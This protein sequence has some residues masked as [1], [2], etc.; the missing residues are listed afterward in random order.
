MVATQSQLILLKSQEIARDIIAKAV[1]LHRLGLGVTDSYESDVDIGLSA[2]ESQ[3]L[4]ETSH[5]VQEVIER[6]LELNQADGL[7][8]QD[9]VDDSEAVM[10][11]FEAVDPMKGLSPVESHIFFRAKEM[12]HDSVARAIVINTGIKAMNACLNTQSTATAT[13]DSEFRRNQSDLV[14]DRVED[15]VYKVIRKAIKMNL[16]AMEEKSLHPEEVKRD[17]KG[18][19]PPSLSDT[20]PV[21]PKGNLKKGKHLSVLGA[22]SHV[23]N[24]VK[25]RNLSIVALLHYS[26]H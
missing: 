5:L 14:M 25:P 6:A 20:S 26:F 9:T 1:E 8:K 4:F 10:A 7:A 12:V 18:R 19:M 16:E 11:V 22:G 13:T 24:L 23:I 15:I 17:G 3:F 2:T 21:P